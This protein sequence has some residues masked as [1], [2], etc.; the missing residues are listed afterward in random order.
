MQYGRIAGK[1]INDSEAEAKVLDDGTFIRV[2]C[3]CHVCSG[4][5]EEG[6]EMGKEGE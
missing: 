6:E 4:N 2:P 5:S 1:T 3:Q